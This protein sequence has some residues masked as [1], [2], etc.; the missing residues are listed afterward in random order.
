MISPELIAGMLFLPSM[1]DNEAIEVIGVERFSKYTGY[2]SSF[3]FSGDFMD[4]KDID[5]MKRHKTRIIA[6]DALV[7]PGE[8]QYRH[9][10]LLREINKAFCGFCDSSKSEKYEKLFKDDENSEVK[11]EEDEIGIVTGNWGCG[12][13]GGDPE[14]KAILQWLAAS[15]VMIII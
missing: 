7:N 9:E 11:F 15:Q 6:I 10:F 1:A 4:K 12:A 13:F 3:R 2:A 8:R 5:M 14:I